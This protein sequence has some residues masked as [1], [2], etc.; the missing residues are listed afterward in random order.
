MGPMIVGREEELV[1]AERAADWLRRLESGDA[2]ENAAFMSWLKESPRHVRE[3]LLLATWDKV[4]K[5]CDPEHRFDVEQLHGSAAQNVVAL[6][7][8]VPSRDGTRATG[9]WPRWRWAAGIAAVTV[10]TA[11]TFVWRWGPL[12]SHAHSYTTDVGEQRSVAL[13]DGSVM[14]LDT[15]SRVRVDY[16]PGSRDIHL[17]DGQALFKVSHNTQ[18]PFRVHTGETVIQAVGTEFDVYRRTERTTVAVLEGT[19]RLAGN[20]ARIVNAGEAA[21]VVTGGHVTRLEPIDV[22]EVT[23]W[24]QRRLVFRKDTLADIAAEFNRYNRT[25]KIRV[26]GEAL[27]LRRFNGVFDADDPMSLLQFL[28]E[29]HDVTFETR[30]DELI[31]KPHAEPG[32]LSAEEHPVMIR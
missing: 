13:A 10:A 15:H 29:D 27:R 24:R 7:A 31:I 19:V 8:A 4:L 22:I 21:N 25:P 3:I 28:K 14:V 16:S 17:I 26:E 1:I 30:G 11:L 5:H 6:Q 32:L 9:G 18:R 20:D 23:A 12:D 2:A